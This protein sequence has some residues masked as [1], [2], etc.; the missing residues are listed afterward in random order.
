MYLPN[1]DFI[2]EQL[3]AKIFW[4]M[5]KKATTTD[6]DLF[7]TLSFKISANLKQLSNYLICCQIEKKKMKKKTTTSIALIGW[8]T[9]AKL[10]KQRSKE[11]E[12]QRSR[13]VKSSVVLTNMQ[14]RWS[15]FQKIF[16]IVKFAFF[17]E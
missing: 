17:N 4:R 10:Q 3:Q 7:D 9:V 8:L 15:D 1:I 6:T 5:K 2:C 14:I 12:K 11:A 13:E 16:D